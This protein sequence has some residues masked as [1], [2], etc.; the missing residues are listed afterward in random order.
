MATQSRT[1][2][3]GPTL[4]RLTVRQFETMIDAGVFPE[5]AHV[6]LLGGLLVDQ[7]TKNPPHDFAV[8]RLD[9]RLRA[10]LL[11]AAWHVREEKA[12]MLGR[13]WRPE[14]D[15]AVVRGSDDLYRN[16]FPRAADVGLLIEVSDT[17]YAAD[18]GA[19]W[20]RY[21]AVGIPVYWIVNLDK[22][23]VEVYGS[24]AGRGK[25]AKYRDV[26]TFGKDDEVPVV[27]D[28][29]EVGRIVVKDILP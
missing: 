24:P 26:A 9:S 3:T 12:T 6:E 5:G 23:V 7:M 19:K 21:A 25:L 10:M 1:T 16:R 4:Y 2:T 18:R 20:R 22:R 27:I 8:T 17:S 28:G 11:P 15:L 13:R 14:P 29:R